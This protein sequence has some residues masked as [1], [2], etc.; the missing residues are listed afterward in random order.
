MA[1]LSLDWRHD[2]TMASY[3]PIPFED[4]LTILVGIFHQ[5]R[6]KRKG[7]EI[8]CVLREGTLAERETFLFVKEEVWKLSRFCHFNSQ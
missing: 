5:L 7:R 6:D 4:V 3:R 2:N 8:F 1:F